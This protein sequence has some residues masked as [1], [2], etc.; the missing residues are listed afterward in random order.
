[1][2]AH[3]LVKSGFDRVS[4]K[5]ISK[6]TI[7]N[8]IDNFGYSYA[9]GGETV[10]LSPVSHPGLASTSASSV[11]NGFRAP[12]GVMWDMSDL[13]PIVRD[14]I[15]RFFPGGG[16]GGTFV[17]GNG[18][19]VTDRPLIPEF[20]DKMISGTLPRGATSYIDLPDGTVGCPSGYHPEKSGKGYCV[21]NR[22]MN[23]L[24]PRA[25]SRASR[26][27][28]GFARAVKRARTL[29]RICRSL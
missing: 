22:R 27:V 21:R 23:S 6:G 7:R 5:N 13:G 2:P 14:V 11:L 4:T 15:D 19:P 28:G 29:K 9:I 8:L 1:M 16:G 17:A 20:I 10:P 3:A 25:L 18:G 24:N 26:R 12:A